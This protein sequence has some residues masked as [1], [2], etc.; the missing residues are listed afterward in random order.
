[1]SAH[2]FARSSLLEVASIIPAE[3]SHLDAIVC[4]ERGIVPGRILM[5]E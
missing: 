5:P 2:A 3:R 4:G 1:M